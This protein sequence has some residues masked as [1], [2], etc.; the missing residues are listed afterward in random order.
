MATFKIK[1]PSARFNFRVRRPDGLGAYYV[2]PPAPPLPKQQKNAP[3]AIPF[4]PYA[5]DMPTQAGSYLAKSVGMGGMGAMGSLYMRT[6]PPVMP[7][8][9][10]AGL[11]C[12][13]KNGMGAGTNDLA[14]FRWPRAL[15]GMGAGTNDLRGVKRIR[16]RLGQPPAL[17]SPDV[18]QFGLPGGVTSDDN[19]IFAPG[20]AAYNQQM[21]QT[22]VSAGTPPGV[23]P[24]EYASFVSS[25][26]GVPVN[27]S[28]PNAIT[29]WLN[30]STAI[31]GANI[32]NE[33]LVGGVAIAV[34]A[35]TALKH[36]RKR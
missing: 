10:F 27:A 1:V 2:N 12:C 23:T 3:S 16:T 21:A 18:S 19:S 31:G 30:G 20:G 6:K 22:L 5:F 35:L 29:S 15:S 25:A 14:G 9:G 24:T 17:P 13:S 4:S 34:I 8:P 26:T 32:S 7:T 36:K 33:A 28:A 11:G